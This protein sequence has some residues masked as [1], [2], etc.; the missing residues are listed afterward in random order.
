MTMVPDLKV[1]SQMFIAEGHGTLYDNYQ[2]G[3]SLGRGTFGEVFLCT[4]YETKE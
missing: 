3:K 4:H 2:V 1:S